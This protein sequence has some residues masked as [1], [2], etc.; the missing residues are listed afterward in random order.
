MS[1][2]K[3]VSA[4]DAVSVVCSGD[5][6]A[7]SGYGGH[8]V[9]EQVLVALENRFLETGDPTNLTLIWAGGQGDLAERV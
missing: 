1:I 7:S 5:H 6:V 3:V 9:A 4:A 2:S 8:G